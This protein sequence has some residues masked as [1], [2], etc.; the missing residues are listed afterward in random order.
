MLE[1]YAIAITSNFELKEALASMSAMEC[2]IAPNML[3]GSR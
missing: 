3:S 2:G 1:A